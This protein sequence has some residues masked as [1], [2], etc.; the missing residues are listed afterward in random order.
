[1]V[2][3]SSEINAAVLEEDFVDPNGKERPALVLTLKDGSKRPLYYETDKNGDITPEAYDKMNKNLQPYIQNKADLGTQGKNFESGKKLASG[4]AY[5]GTPK[6]SKRQRFYDIDKN[7]KKVT[8]IKKTDGSVK[9]TI[10][11]R[12]TD[13]LR[14][15]RA[16]DDT[17][18]EGVADL[19]ELLVDLS[20]N[21]TPIDIGKI[22]IERTHNWTGKNTMTIKVGKDTFTLDFDVNFKDMDARKTKLKS[23]LTQILKS[24]HGGAK[25][26]LPSDIRLKENISL[27][28]KSPRGIN[29]YEFKYIGAEGRYQGVMAQEVPW[30]SEKGDDGFLRVDYSQVDVPFIKI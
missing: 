7:P 29:I 16:A 25:K 15:K 21:H 2:N 9:Y 22:K 18:D 23:L 17:D 5:T 13:I 20:K 3:E 24:Y 4:T 1:M 8:Y 26:T 30:A 11:Q 19:Q 6:T 28:G 10:D 12:L 14:D 27:I